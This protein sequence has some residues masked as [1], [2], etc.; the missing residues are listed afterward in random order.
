MSNHECALHWSYVRFHLEFRCLSETWH[1]GTEKAKTMKRM[2]LNYQSKMKVVAQDLDWL[3]VYM[4]Y[5]QLSL[6]G[7]NAIVVQE[8]R[9]IPDERGNMRMINFYGLIN[10]KGEMKLPSDKITAIFSSTENN[11]RTYFCGNDEQQVDVIRFWREHNLGEINYSEKENQ[12]VN[13]VTNNVN[14]VDQQNTVEKNIVNST[15]DTN[16][17]QPQSIMNQAVPVIQN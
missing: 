13:S 6:L 1:L 14:T 3:S 12:T 2:G 10:Y 17:A 8:N 5:I 16:T 9:E 11:E 15:N 7:I 4:T